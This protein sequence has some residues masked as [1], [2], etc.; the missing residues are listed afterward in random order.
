MGPY[1]KF[2]MR[3][4]FLR[5]VI[6]N[7]LFLV[8]VAMAGSVWAHP[9]DPGTDPNV[10]HACVRQATG[11]V[12][13]V[14]PN[15]QCRTGDPRFFENPLHWN[16]QGPQGA[17]GD[18]GPQGPQG[19]QGAQGAQGDPGPQG[20]QGL[21]GP[22]GAQGAQGPAGPQTGLFVTCM[23]VADLGFADGAG[24]SCVRDNTMDV[25][26]S[27]AIIPAGAVNPGFLLLDGHVT[28]NSNIGSIE[29]FPCGVFPCP[30]GF[31]GWRMVVTPQTGDPISIKLLVFP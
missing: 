27:T 29:I 11:V 21:Q 10:I 8:G 28:A 31:A 1:R 13:I 25:F 17:Q 16:I 20:P 7:L 15:G 3:G 19:L 12:R 30:E 2:R 5:I 4:P 26:L 6:T 9:P 22:P 24:F 18:P 23:N 14:G